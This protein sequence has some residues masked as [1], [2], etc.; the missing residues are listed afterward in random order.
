MNILP[1]L[2]QGLQLPHFLRQSSYALG[3]VFEG[4][5]PPLLKR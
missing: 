5:N 2:K 1:L 4:A 3:N